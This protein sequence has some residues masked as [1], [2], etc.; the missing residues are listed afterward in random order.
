[1]GCRDNSCVH[2]E[3]YMGCNADSH[4]FK[5][6][7][8]IIYSKLCTYVGFLKETHVHIKK[9]SFLGYLWEFSDF[10]VFWKVLAD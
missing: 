6:Y 5:A 9:G 2:E 7:A 10:G 1:M 4:V 8:S 3:V